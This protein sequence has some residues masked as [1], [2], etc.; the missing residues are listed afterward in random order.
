[1]PESIAQIKMRLE[2]KTARGSV[3]RDIVND[4]LA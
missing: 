1:M 4:R 3:T 2:K